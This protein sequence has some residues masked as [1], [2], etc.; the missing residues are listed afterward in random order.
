MNL[1]SETQNNNTMK[2]HIP[3]SK[4]L[5]H[6]AIVLITTAVASTSR[7]DDLTA[8]G[9]FDNDGLVDIAAVTSSTTVTVYLA[10]PDGSYTV[11]ATLSAPRNKKI[12]FVQLFDYNSDGALD[13]IASGPASGGW[14]TSY[15]L[16]GNGDGTFGSMTT[17]RWRWKGNFGFF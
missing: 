10:N 9:D 5:I 2:K 1:T 13:V 12:T 3:I 4:T 8:Y 6:S 11:S 15:I 7:A 14:V 17:N 16:L